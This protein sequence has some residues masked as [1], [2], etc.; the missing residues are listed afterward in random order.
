MSPVPNG[1]EPIGRWLVMSALWRGGAIHRCARHWRAR[2]GR[3]YYAGRA[4]TSAETHSAAR[5]RSDAS[6]A[7]STSTATTTPTAGS[8]GS[9]RRACPTALYRS[10]CRSRRHSA[11]AHQCTKRISS[12]SGRHFST[13]RRHRH[14]S[15]TRL[16]RLYVTHYQSVAII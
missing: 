15:A 1:N 9:T 13:R 6:P 8:S 12:R 2:A 11:L 3:F 14:I 10:R 4:T 16:D 5:A 7:A